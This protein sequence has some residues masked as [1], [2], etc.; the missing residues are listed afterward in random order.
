MKTI[1]N[2]ES[3]STYILDM[4][5]NTWKRTK[6]GEL[7]PTSSLPLRTTSGTFNHLEGVEIGK[8]AHIHG[9]GLEFGLRW[10]HTSKIVSITHEEDNANITS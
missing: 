4:T 10:I 5:N 6:R 2:T 3:G 9:P 7:L 8:R 1:I